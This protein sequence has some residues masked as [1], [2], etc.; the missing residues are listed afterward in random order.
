MAYQ[1]F[2]QY[3]TSLKDAFR[4]WS[5]ARPWTHIFT[6]S[7]STPRA[8][9]T[10]VKIGKDVLDGLTQRLGEPP[11]ALLLP[12]TNNGLVAPHLHALIE[13]P[14]LIP[15]DLEHF[16]KKRAHGQAQCEAYDPSGGWLEYML[17]QWDIDGWDMF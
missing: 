4:E 2:N 1:Q 16:W 14:R 9:G 6:G 12:S 8:S 17:K 10:V 7:F 3:S 15:S 11:V 5:R 13:A